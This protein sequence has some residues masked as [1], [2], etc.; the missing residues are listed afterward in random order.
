VGRGRPLLWS[1]LWSTFTF[2]SIARC[3]AREQQAGLVATSAVDSSG[4][5]MEEGREVP[6]WVT[7]IEAGARLASVRRQRAPM[8]VL[9]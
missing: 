1:G 5:L 2:T 3:P 6:R 9:A 8:M 4:L 7:L